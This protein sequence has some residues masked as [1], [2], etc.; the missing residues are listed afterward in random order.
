MNRYVARIELFV[1]GINNEEAVAEA[2]KLA[3]ELDSKYDCKAELT[4]MDNLNFGKMT[5]KPVEI[6]KI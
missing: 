3:K 4:K 1:Y 6:E 5:S 2:R